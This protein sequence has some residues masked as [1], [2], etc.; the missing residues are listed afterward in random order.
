[1]LFVVKDLISQQMKY[2]RQSFDLNT[3][4]NTLRMIHRLYLL[5]CVDFRARAGL[6]VENTKLG[7][8]F[9][10]NVRLKLFRNLFYSIFRF[11]PKFIAPI[12]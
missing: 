2:I 9:G 10:F 4:H 5:L 6:S 12:L 7:A 1:M 11:L 3:V 8:Q